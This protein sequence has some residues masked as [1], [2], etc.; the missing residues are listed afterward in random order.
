MGYYEQEFLN[1]D[2]DRK[3]EILGR[4]FDNTAFTRYQNLLSGARSGMAAAFLRQM[5]YERAENIGGF[6]GYTGPVETGTQ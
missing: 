6:E 1:A 2:S 3:N 4:L 5:G